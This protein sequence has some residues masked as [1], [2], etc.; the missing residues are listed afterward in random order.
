MRI[1]RA[2]NLLNWS[3]VIILLVATWVPI[4]SPAG[5]QLLDSNVGFFDDSFGDLKEELETAR[6]DGKFGVMVMFETEECPWCTRMKSQVLNRVHVQDYYHDHFRLIALDAEGDVIINDFE[7][8]E[9]TSKDF[10]L[11][12][13]RVRAT[14]VFAFFDLEGTLVMRYTGALKNAHDFMLLGKFVVEGHYKNG[15]FNRYRRENQPS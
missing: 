4:I 2:S 11:K 13:M 12:H 7:G 1:Y 9:I 5:E 8:G 15:R 10:S 3:A 6:T 14:P